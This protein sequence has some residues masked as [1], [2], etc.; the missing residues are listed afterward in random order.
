MDDTTVTLLRSRLGG[1]AI[2]ASKAEDAG[3][4]STSSDIWSD[5]V[6]SVL[7]RAPLEAYINA[8]VKR[9]TRRAPR[10]LREGDVYIAQL[11]EPLALDAFKRPEDTAAF[12]RACRKLG[13]YIEDGTRESRERA[14]VVFAQVEEQ[15]P[16]PE[17]P[18]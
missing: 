9:S 3:E 5:E 13:A 7:V 11:R 8:A 2:A 6:D 17:E 16:S 10:T 12:V 18:R 15:M 1:Q 14:K 4:P